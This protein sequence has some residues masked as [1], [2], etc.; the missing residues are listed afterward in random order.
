MTEIKLLQ[1]SGPILAVKFVDSLLLSGEGPHLVANDVSTTSRVFQKLAFKKNKIHGIAVSSKNVVGLWGGRSLAFESLAGLLD[2]KHAIEELAINDWIVHVGFSTDGEVAYVLTSHNLVLVINVTTH[3]ILSSK[4]CGEKSLL[5]SGYVSVTG[6]E[7]TVAAGTVMSGIVIWNLATETIAHNLKGHEGSIFGVRIS[8]DGKKLISCSDDR[9]IKLW[10]LET[11]KNIATGWG[12][13]AR[14]WH[15]QFFQKNTKILSTS[16]DCT[17]RVWDAESEDLANVEVFNAHQGKNAWCGDVNEEIGIIAT[18]GSD[19]R[20]RIF[21]VQESKREGAVIK[22]WSPESVSDATETPFTN[23]EIFKEYVAVAGGVVCVTSEG[24]LFF[25]NKELQWKLLL[26]DPRFAGFSLVRS[27]EIENVVVVTSKDGTHLLIKLAED[28]SVQEQ[29]SFQTEGLKGKVTNVLVTTDIDTMMMV[30][31]SPVPSDPF[32]L[33]VFSSGLDVKSTLKLPKPDTRF[34][35][36]SLAYDVQND[37]ILISSRYT[38]LV[39][40]ELSSQTLLHTWKKFVPGDTVS[41]VRVSL[42]AKNKVVFSVVIRDGS[43]YYL[44]VTNEIGEIQSSILGENRIQKGFL[45]GMLESDNGDILLYGFRSS[46][47]FVWNETQQYEV[48]TETCGGPHRQWLFKRLEGDSFMFMYTRA[49]SIN[50]RVTG[51]FPLHSRAIN[52][53][54]NGR[55]IRSI[56]I[57]QKVRADRTNLMLTG[58]EDTCIRLSVVDDA[59]H[60]KN[61]WSERK[62]VS[63]IQK[64]KFIDSNLAISSA[65]REEL[66][67]WSIDDTYPKRPYISVLATLAPTSAN[68]DL[69]IMDFDTVPVL[70]AEKTV[71]YL[72][73]TVYSDSAIRIWYFDLKSRSFKLLVEDR[74]ST[75]CLLDAALITREAA[76]YLMTGATDGYISVWNITEILDSSLSVSGGK[77]LLQSL[78]TDASTK[79]PEC[80]VKQQIHQSGIKSVDIRSTPEAV[81]IIT[82]G[83]DNSLSLLRLFSRN[84]SSLEVLSLVANAASS[85][86][87]SVEFIPDSLKVFAT[88]VDQII[89]IWDYSV[90]DQLTLEKKEYVTV[91]DTGCSA[92]ASIGDKPIGFVGGAGLS[93]YSLEI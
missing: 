62:H 70:E 45:E 13:G 80:L 37:W 44:E 65:A 11:G 28:G 61:V 9:S 7:V 66:F 16:E 85:T 64:V 54:N 77:C 8:D 63:G 42:S 59:K 19:G 46:Q 60:I 12:H 67:V 88:S 2:E 56:S 81:Y 68:P 79:L 47:F 31:E 51:K 32:V 30:V 27:F 49:S 53:G 74:Y 48:F 86:I 50:V 73:A 17:V 23:N 41:S 38:T 21:D 20:L 1:S 5:Y 90:D 43:Y 92:V 34:V 14:I 82:G 15:L 72:L 40:Y 89:R 84:P 3:K 25:L 71:G 35:S 4:S 22:Q 52:V 26:K 91:A 55:E 33:Y 6:T 76:L 29:K 78:K 87:T 93:V 39:M 36:S 75:C 10:D 18:G 58:S 24:S 83:D 69:R 57:Q